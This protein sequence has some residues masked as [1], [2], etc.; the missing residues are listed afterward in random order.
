MPDA[1]VIK[2]PLADGGEGTLEILERE[3]NAQKIE[4]E[5]SDP[6]FR[7]VKAYYLLNGGKAYI[8]MAK[9][10][11]LPL[12]KNFEKSPL[13][14]STYGTGELISDAVQ[15]GAKEIFVMIGGSA[16]NDGGCGMA[17]ALGVRFYSS[18]GT[19]LKAIR[20]QDLSRISTLDISALERFVG[21]SFKV[22]SDV[23]NPLTG[24]NGASYVFGKQKGA[25]EMEIEQLD[26]GLQNLAA[27]LN[28][29]NE[30]KPGAGAAGGL[31]YGLMSFVDARLGSG[32][33][34][35]FDILDFDG[36]LAGVDLIIT[37][38]GKLDGQTLS[39][40]VI[41]GVNERAKE[42]N[43]PIGIICGISDELSRVKANL[44]IEMIYQVS[45]RANSFQDSMQNANKYVEELAEELILKFTGT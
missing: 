29:G 24:P 31:G 5:V 12:L 17:E 26:L 11:G 3:L 15:R 25:S 37:G 6:L 28:N 19:E 36:H 13:K 22:L 30:Q 39:G 43:I 40:K 8:E 33:N 35:V 23:Q 1:E 2:L 34:Q 10:S 21:V 7:P 44:G 4:L 45:E 41:S 27:V 38:E 42:S 32:I 14:T 9:A 18:N 16:T 20:G